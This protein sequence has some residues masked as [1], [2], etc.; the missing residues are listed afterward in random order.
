MRFKRGN[1]YRVRDGVKE[2]ETLTRSLAAGLRGAN[3]FT[4]DKKGNKQACEIPAD[5]SLVIILT[6]RSKMA[7]YVQ[8]LHPTIGPIYIHRTYIEEIDT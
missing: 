5:G 8:V 6:S 3:I 2:N 4:L 7:D 1:L